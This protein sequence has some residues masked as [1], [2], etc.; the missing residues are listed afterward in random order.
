MGEITYPHCH[1]AAFWLFSS[2]NSTFSKERFLASIEAMLNILRRH[3]LLFPTYLVGD[4]DR[5]DLRGLT[6]REIRELIHTSYLSGKVGTF[7]P[8]VGGYGIVRLN[9]GESFIQPDLIFL[10][11]IELSRGTVSVGTDVSIW[12]P[13]MIDGTSYRNWQ[14]EMAELNAPRLETA[15]KEMATELPMKVYPASEEVDSDGTMWIKG[16]RLYTDPYVLKQK[17]EEEPPPGGFDLQ[18]H[19]LDWTVDWNS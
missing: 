19:L 16:F 2:E 3:E 18:K 8:R 10:D 7:I 4:S 17:L 5:I 13:I 12:T 14:I 11:S 6:A 1:S 9:T 15:L